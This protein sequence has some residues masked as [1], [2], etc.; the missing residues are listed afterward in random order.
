MPY[1]KAKKAKSPYADRRP[2]KVNPDLKDAMKGKGGPPVKKKKSVKTRPHKIKPRKP[3]KGRSRAEKM[4]R[5]ERLSPSKKK[6]KR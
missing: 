6:K 3:I 4:D 1:N 2:S 5:G